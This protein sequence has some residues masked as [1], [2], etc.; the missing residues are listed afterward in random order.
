MKKIYFNSRALF[1]N[2]TKEYEPIPGQLLLPRW[3]KKG[4]RYKKDKEG[5]R[6]SCQNEE[7][8]SWKT[9]PAILDSLLSGY[10]LRTPC[11]I[12][13]VRQNDNFGIVFEKGFELFGGIRGEESGFPTPPG[14]ESIHF[15]WQINWM[16][17]VP[18]GYTVL[19]THPLN[20]FD[21]PFLTISGFIDCDEFGYAGKAPFFIK[22]G[23]EGFIPAGTPYMQIIPFHQE[24]WKSEVNYYDEEQLL[25]I[26]K[27]QKGNFISKTK[28]NYKEKFWIR[29]KYE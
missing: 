22:K 16:P 20:R 3:F 12:L 10:L 4:D 2:N 27:E 8:G 19:A 24:E 29:K 26:F 11:D 23:F 1:N 6:A 21:L 17:Q 14:Y 7:I 15:F 25:K 9:C 13:I 28:T 18:K 5:N